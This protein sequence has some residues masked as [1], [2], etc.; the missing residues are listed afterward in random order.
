[1]PRRATHVVTS[2]IAGVLFALNQS[3]SQPEPARLCEALGGLAGGYLGGR[4]PDILD[5][6]TSPRHRGRAHSLTV[7]D[8]LVKVSREDL[9]S[10]QN[11]CR[12]WADGFARQRSTLPPDSGLRILCTLAEIV[13]CSRAFSPAS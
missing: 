6:P 8:G 7:A 5:P 9:Q 10:W 3:K 1:M 13:E 2:G 11:N 12:T 4:A